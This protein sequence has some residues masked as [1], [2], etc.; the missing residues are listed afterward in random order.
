MFCVTETFVSSHTFANTERSWV[1]TYAAIFWFALMS[2]CSLSRQPPGKETPQKG[3]AA[4]FNKNSKWRMKR[5]FSLS[6]T[7]EDLIRCFKKVYC[8]QGNQYGIYTWKCCCNTWRKIR[9]PGTVLTRER[10]LRST[11][12]CVRESC[13]VQTVKRTTEWR[14]MLKK[15]FQKSVELN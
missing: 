6:Y 7:Y 9:Q 10:N 1:A 8:S 13:W 14:S 15:M 11:W 3:W 4:D 12:I 2:K 5:G